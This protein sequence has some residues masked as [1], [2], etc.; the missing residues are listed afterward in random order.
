MAPA[1]NYPNY[2]Q[3]MNIQ[4]FAHRLASI[5]E[6]NEQVSNTSSTISSDIQH[7]QWP[8]SI[9]YNAHRG[10]SQ[11]AITRIS[12]LHRYSDMLRGQYHLAR[13]SSFNHLNDSNTGLTI[14]DKSGDS[15]KL[16]DYSVEYRDGIFRTTWVDEK[17]TR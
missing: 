8:P 1:M 3:A 11:S 10:P 4:S 2:S 7:I 16:A 13:F 5:M 15:K 6:T 12:P 14:I 9:A 17:A